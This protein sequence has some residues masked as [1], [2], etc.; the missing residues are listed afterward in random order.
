MSAAELDSFVKLAALACQVPMVMLTF[1]DQGGDCCGALLGMA[2]G[3]RSW[4]G[5]LSAAITAARERV[6]VADAST[7]EQLR[8]CDLVA[9]PPYI[10]CFAGVPIALAGGEMVGVLT[11]ADT[12]PKTLDASQL[13]AL[14]LLARHIAASIKQRSDLRKQADS[15]AREL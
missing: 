11:V 2:D 13:A 8:H 12:L 7:N 3:Q 4:Q 9:G 14:D 1:P 5:A 15:L 10:K 6:Q